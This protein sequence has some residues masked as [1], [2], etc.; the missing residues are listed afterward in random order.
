[1][2][3]NL[4]KATVG[5]VVDLPLSIVSDTVTMGGAINNEESAIAKSLSNIVKNVDK[6]VS[7][8]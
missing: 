1:M 6:A 5:I 2:F 3:E 8:D 7:P 4:L